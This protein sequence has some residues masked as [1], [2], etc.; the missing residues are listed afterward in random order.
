M[1]DSHHLTVT[2][3]LKFQRAAKAESMLWTL[4]INANY[5]S[6]WADEKNI[7]NQKKD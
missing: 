7:E 5:T 4:Q 6:K 3:V 2:T 1:P